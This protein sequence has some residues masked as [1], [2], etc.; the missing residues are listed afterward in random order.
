LLRFWKSEIIPTPLRQ[1]LFAN[2]LT[3]SNPLRKGIHIVKMTLRCLVVALFLA[4]ISAPLTAF[5]K[6][7]DPQPPVVHKPVLPPDGNP[8]PSGGH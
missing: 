4:A 6:N 3:R 8:N 1:R 7:D 2:T 5:A